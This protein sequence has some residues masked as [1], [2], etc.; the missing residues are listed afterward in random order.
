MMVYAGFMVYD[1]TPLRISVIN[2]V[3][4][5]MGHNRSNA[6]VAFTRL[7]NEHPDMTANFSDV[8]FPDA[9]GR[10]GWSL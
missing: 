7:K 3:A 1:D 10:K 2:V 8:K 4:A 6:A 9:C 5:I